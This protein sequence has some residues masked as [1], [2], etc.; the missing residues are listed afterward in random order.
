MKKLYLV[1]IACFTLVGVNAQNVGIG[2]TTPLRPLH[3]HHASTPYAQFT[4][5]TTGTTSNDGSFVGAFGKNFIIYN[6]ESDGG[7]EWWIDGSKKMTLDSAGKLG[8]GKT[9]ENELDVKGSLR[10]ESLTSTGAAS[11]KMY[12]GTSSLS[13]IQ[14]YKDISSPSAMGYLGFSP[15]GDY[16]VIQRGNALSVDGT[17]VGVGTVSPQSKLHVPFGSDAGLASNGFLMLG[18]STSTNIVADNNEILAR[19]NGAASDL[20]LQNDA[21]NVIMCA[22]ELGGVG[23]GVNSGASIPAGYLLAVDGKIISEELKVQLSGSWPD[24]VFAD[25]YKLKSFDHLRSFIKQNKHLPNI[26]SAAEVEKNGIE[27]GDMQ[28]RMIEKIEELTLYILELENR[29]NE[30]DKKLNEKK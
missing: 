16:A 22:S 12:G 19:N 18:Q 29:L 9:P 1:I 4:N 25:N 15:T 23:I 13:Y 20:F 11:I 28:K 8:I 3:I 21:G 24:Y 14:F 6:E 26:P 27:V 2:T 30:M 17:G 5:T 7:V 10:L